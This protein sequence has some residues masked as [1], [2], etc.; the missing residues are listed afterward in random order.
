M[1]TEIDE[2]LYELSYNSVTNLVYTIVYNKSTSKTSYI[3]SN[4]NSILQEQ[5]N[6]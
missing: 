3:N 1:I 5:Y 4:S 2:M 6:I